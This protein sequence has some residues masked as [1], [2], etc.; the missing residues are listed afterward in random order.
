MYWFGWG[1]WVIISFFWPK[2]KRRLFSAALL[3]LLLIVLPV[4]LEQTDIHLAFIL[5]TIYLCWCM[6]SYSFSRLIHVLIT[7]ITV[8]AAYGGF[9]MLLIFDPVIA[10]TDSRWMTS[11]LVGIISFFLSHSYKERLYVALLGLSQGEWL[12]GF[13]LGRHMKMEQTVGDLYFFDIIAIVCC[14]FSIVWAVHQLSVWISNQLL[15]ETD[16]RVL[17]ES[18]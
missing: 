18:S 13:V 6:R 15:T 9:Q 16:P 10:Y 5:F 8:A 12:T 7:S 11:C 2:T 14:L 4:R 3:L 17:K 1:L